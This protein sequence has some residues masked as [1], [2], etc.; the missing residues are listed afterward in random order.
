MNMGRN[1]LDEF[2]DSWRK[3]RLGGGNSCGLNSLV[4]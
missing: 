2:D 4:S 3:D 1:G